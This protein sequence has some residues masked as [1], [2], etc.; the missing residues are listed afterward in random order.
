MVDTV[1]L[2]LCAINFGLP[3]VWFALLGYL[4]ITVSRPSKRNVCIYIC[5]VAAA[6]VISTSHIYHLIII[7]FTFINII[8]NIVII[9]FCLNIPLSIC[10]CVC[11]QF[12]GFPVMS[13]AAVNRMIYLQKL[14]EQGWL[15]ARICLLCVSDHCVCV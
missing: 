15:L 6:Y 13:L 10:V 14:G 4:I 12:S 7:S 3:L 5:S 11:D 8:I 1:Y 2:L 9:Y